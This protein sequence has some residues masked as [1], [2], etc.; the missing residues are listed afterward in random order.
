MNIKR[1]PLFLL[2]LPLCLHGQEE[3]ETIATYAAWELNRAQS[4]WFGSSNAAGMA[5]TPLRNYNL[6]EAQYNSISGNYK[7]QQEGDTD[8]AAG[9]NAD[10]A[11][12][13]GNCYLWGN[14]SFSDQHLGGSTFNTNRYQPTPSMP[15]YV[16][17]T[18]RSDWKKQSY[19]MAFK[20]AFPL[21]R[22][23]TLGGEV[24]YVTRKAAKQLDPRSVIH[25]YAIELKPAI[26]F[27]LSPRHHLGFNLLYQ[28]TF[29]RNTF[30]N[31]LNY[32]SERV[33]I[34]RGLGNYTTAVVG[35]IGGISPFYYP[36]HQYGAGLQYHLL[37]PLQQLLVELT[38]SRQQTDAFED[39][40]KPRRR[41]TAQQTDLDATL[42]WIKSTPDATHKLLAQAS[43]ASAKG[44]E[45]LQEYVSQY[46][47]NRWITLAEYVKSDYSQQNIAL[48]YDFYRGAPLRYTWKTGLHA[49]Y[50]SQQDEYISPQSLFNAR[51]VYAELLADKQ[52]NPAPGHT[53][54]LGLSAGYKRHLSGEYLYNGPEPTSPI[55]RQF[56]A[57]DLAH[58]AAHAL[59]TGLRAYYS[60]ALQSDASLNL[61]LQWQW[62]KPTEN[63]LTDSS[64]ADRHHITAAVAY[65]F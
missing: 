12:R 40:T 17:D 5:L 1:L 7:L 38:F 50:S 45:Y 64:T 65:F 49:T 58:L 43:I 60:L 52:W 6:L 51:N 18:A 31:S 46:E 20:A 42:Q 57:Q 2:F 30:T 29:D 24:H 32:N 26:V 11:L 62:I 9:L 61:R 36:S 15:Y 33:Y 23:L 21:S 16:A 56:F 27:N 41:G 3:E 59:Q 34:M 47:I 39:P 25:S 54:Q 63:P 48:Q 44:I 37:K 4:L 13:L 35:G 14:F 55:V 22:R 10:G 28:N 19:D 53:L 8:R